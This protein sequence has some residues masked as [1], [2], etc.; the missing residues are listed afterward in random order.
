MFICLNVVNARA[1]S[2]PLPKSLRSR[3]ELKRQDL[4][5][6]R[7]PVDVINDE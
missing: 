1:I 4:L 3:P 6:V 5:G 7:V 2:A